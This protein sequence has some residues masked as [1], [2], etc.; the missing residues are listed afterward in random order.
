MSD[1][2]TFKDSTGATLTLETTEVTSGVHRPKHA[3]PDGA[4]VTLGAKAD[5][6]VSNPASTASLVALTK[7]QLTLT[8]AV[9]E[10][11]PGTDTASSGLN[12]RLQ[13]IAQRLTD[14]ITAVGGYLTVRGYGFDVA[15]TP[16]VTNGAYSAGDIMGALMTFTVA[17]AN[18]EPVIITGAQVSCKADV[19]PAL[20]LVLFN[21]DPSSTTKTDNAAWSLNAADAFKVI[22]SIPFGSVWTD[23]GTPN[24]IRADNLGIVAKPV[25][26]GQAIYGILIDA[27]GV[28][29]TS[30]SD[31]QVR[32]RGLGC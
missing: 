23:H 7:G 30:T 22:G 4:D 29:L 26:G 19:K 16:T 18:D 5:A 15:V 6:A 31:I 27:T 21:A 11:A 9:N 1:N 13:R 25:S 17:R 2:F 24:T 12:G 28:T 10:T 8:G 32:L 14:L 3:V 20:T